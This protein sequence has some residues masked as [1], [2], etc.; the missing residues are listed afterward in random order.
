[1][2]ILF[3]YPMPPLTIQP[4][5]VQASNHGTDYLCFYCTFLWTIQTPSILH[6]PCSFG[7]K[8]LHFLTRYQFG[9]SMVLFSGWKKLTFAFSHPWLS[10]ALIHSSVEREREIMRDIKEKLCYVALDCEE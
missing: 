10:L 4:F 7:Y 6:I 9:S 8:Y 1:M 2:A 5:T 3:A